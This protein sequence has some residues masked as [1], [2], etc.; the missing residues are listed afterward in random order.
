L[1]FW[2]DEFER[3]YLPGYGAKARRKHFRDVDIP[4][5]LIREWTSERAGAPP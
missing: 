1:R 5:R 2:R 4:E 3:A